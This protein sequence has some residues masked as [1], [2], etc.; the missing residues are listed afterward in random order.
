MPKGGKPWR[1]EVPY[2]SQGDGVRATAGV[3]YVGNIYNNTLSFNIGAQFSKKEIIIHQGAKCA[4]GFYI[5]DA[6]VFYKTGTG[7]VI[8]CTQRSK[9]AVH[10]YPMKQEE[11]KQLAKSIRQAERILRWRTG[12]YC[13][14]ETRKKK[15]MTLRRQAAQERSRLKRKHGN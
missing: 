5:G 1:N 2:R 3:V 14:K 11:R 6:F 4:T 9:K 12:S 8:R 13:E 10:L 15:A 7:I